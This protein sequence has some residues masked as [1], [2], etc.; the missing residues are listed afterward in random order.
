LNKQLA[1]KFFADEIWSVWHMLLLKICTATRKLHLSR[2][3][4]D[5]DAVHRML[6]FN[7]CDAYKGIFI[8]TYKLPSACSCHIPAVKA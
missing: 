8:D 5:M 3:V 2:F 6:S 7:P 1:T 4:I